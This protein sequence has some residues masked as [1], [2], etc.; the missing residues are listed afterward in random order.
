MSSVTT[1]PPT[2][3]PSECAWCGS[4][5]PQPKVAPSSP[6]GGADAPSAADDAAPPCDSCH[7]VSRERWSVAACS[8]STAFHS[9]P[10]TSPSGAGAPSCSSSV[11]WPAAGGAPAGCAAPSSSPPASAS[12][13]IRQSAVRS[14]DPVEYTLIASS[15][16]SGAGHDARHHASCGCAYTRSHRTSFVSSLKSSTCSSFGARSSSVATRNLLWSVSPS[17]AARQ[18]ACCFSW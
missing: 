16:C 9:S 4:Q 7:S 17:S 12:P 2:P 6:G 14:S 18:R 1:S 5:R 11:S 3:T 15:E 13:S 10:R 8:G